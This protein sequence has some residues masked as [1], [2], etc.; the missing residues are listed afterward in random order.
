MKLCVLSITAVLATFVVAN[1]ILNPRA[2]SR[3][4]RLFGKEG[5]GLLTVLPVAE[6]NHPGY[7]RFGWYGKGSQKIELFFSQYE[8]RGPVFDYP[9]KGYEMYISR[10]PLSASRFLGNTPLTL[11]Q[12]CARGHGSGASWR[13]IL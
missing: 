8:N 9:P 7:F 4:F 6:A 2:P 12:G 13:H 5:L 1:P 11:L 10:F 3:P